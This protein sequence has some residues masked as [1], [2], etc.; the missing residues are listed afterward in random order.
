MEQTDFSLQLKSS[1]RSGTHLHKGLECIL[2]LRGKLG[3]NLDGT[4]RS[5]VEDDLFVLNKNQIHALSCKENCLILVLHL[6]ANML[7]RECGVLAQSKVQC[8]PFLPG[9]AQNE[10][11]FEIKRVM[12]ELFAVQMEKTYGYQLIMNAN[13]LRLLQLLY[14]TFSVEAMADNT[15]TPKLGT[16]TADIL[17][18]ID[19]NYKSPL[20]LPEIAARHYMSP[21]YFSRY[22]KKATGANYLYYLQMLRADKSIPQLLHSEASILEI[23]LEHGFKN[24]RAY[25]N[26]FL[27]RYGQTPSQYRKTHKNENNLSTANDTVLLAE[28]TQ[29]DNR[30]EFLRYL[31][32][33]D[34]GLDF[35]HAADTRAEICFAKPAIGQ[36][37]P[38]EGILLI[39]T[40][41]TALRADFFHA[42]SMNLAIN[43][44][45]V[46]F[47]LVS[48][49]KARAGVSPLYLDDLLA[50]VEA[51]VQYGL[52]PFLRIDG[53]EALFTG[54]ND[55]ISQYVRTAVC[56][57][58]EVLAQRFYGQTIRQWKVELVCTHFTKPQSEQ[59]YRETYKAARAFLPEVQ[60]GLFAE[61]EDSHGTAGRFEE[62]LG[63]SVSIGHKP[64]F[65]TFHSFQNRI[66]KWHSKDAQFLKNGQNYHLNKLRTIREICKKLGLSSPLYLTAWNTLSG[67]NQGEIGMYVRTGLIWDTML[68]LSGEVAGVGYRFVTSDICPYSGECNGAPLNLL[69]FSHTKR[70]VYFMAEFF[71]RMVGQTLHFSSNICATVNERHELL[72]AMWNPQLLNPTHAIDNPLTESL[73]KKMQV[74]VS[75]LSQKNYT[76]KRITVDKESNGTISRLNQSGFPDMRDTDALNYLKNTTVGELFVWKETAQEGVLKLTSTV[77]YNGIVL[78]IIA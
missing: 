78:Y 17:Q 61:T 4:T 73:A 19:Q 57:T 51:I 49:S 47:Q 58:L 68:H 46:Y 74:F 59:F 77:S 38:L 54:L 28:E 10:I 6:E 9:M 40:P 21:A 42:A 32:R 43:A 75:G 53:P 69:I 30:I 7:L 25:A 8:H 37:T 72:V 27:Q 48:F 52:K 20:P 64:Q 31:R 71:H 29:D 34:T 22:F 36:F 44:Q 24:A 45:Y 1:V 3:I 76:I 66:K 41:S 56:P 15:D 12:V 55:E 2:V 23:A 70:P 63:Y 5:L 16:R 65:I 33:Y 14:L 26:T 13:L 18:D 67:E 60:I 39:D 35:Q 50:A 11:Y 62:L